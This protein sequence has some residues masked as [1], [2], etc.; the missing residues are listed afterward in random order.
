MSISLD[1]QTIRQ[2]AA[3]ATKGI[4]ND[5]IYTKFLQLI[6]EYDLKGDILDFGA[7]TGNLTQHLYRLSRFKSIT[8][9]DI[10]QH[11][12]E[13]TYPVKWITWDLNN[14]LNISEQIFDVIV[15]A[16]VIEHLENPRGVVREWFRLLRPG[17]TLIFSTPNNQSLRSLLA[18]LLQG[19]FVAFA[20]TC[21][22][23]HITALLKK[24]IQRILSE[25]GFYQQKFVFTDVGNIPKFP[26]WQWQSISLGLLKGSIFSDNLIVICQKPS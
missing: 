8:A 15:S 7:G 6:T 20:D 17:G 23:S 13:I 26:Q 19:H 4:S 12:E 11:S 2:F 24:D 16:E 25:A 9:A 18:L 14:S 22:P 1:T 5:V 21:Y 10:M 3:A